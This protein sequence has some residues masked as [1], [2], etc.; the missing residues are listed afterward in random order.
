MTSADQPRPFPFAGFV[1]RLVAFIID[2]LL[3]L[4]ILAVLRF[5]V[6]A[7][8]NFF[9]TIVP[10]IQLDV[11]ARVAG[12]VGVTSGTILQSVYFVFFWTVTGQTPGMALMGIEVVRKGVVHPTV[13]ASIIRY[14]GLWISFIAL[15][16]GFAWVL[17]DRRRRGWHDILA[18]TYVVY[19]ATARQYHEHVKAA[20]QRARAVEQRAVMES[21]QR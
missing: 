3:I 15:G 11:G 1:S 8:I 2:V 12:L 13:S 7:V 17:I 10:F 20:K 4:A 16:L 18:G 14:F 6:Q 19:A 9:T 21:L 5:T